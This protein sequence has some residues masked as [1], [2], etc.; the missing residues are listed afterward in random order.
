MTGAFPEPPPAQP[1]SGGEAMSGAFPSFL[2]F[3]SLGLGG[4]AI[5]G[6]SLGL[7]VP[8]DPITVDGILLMVPGVIFALVGIVGCL[9][10]WE[11]PQ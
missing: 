9:A 10:Q 1:P 2:F 6:L 11:A 3:L 4:F 5:L 7:F 8:N